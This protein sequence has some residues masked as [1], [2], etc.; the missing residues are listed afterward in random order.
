[1]MWEKGVVENDSPTALACCFWGGQWYLNLDSN[2]Q[3]GNC[4]RTF[5]P[6]R[7]GCGVYRKCRRQSW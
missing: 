2:T 3:D 7:I 1:M 5:I 6:D 4:I